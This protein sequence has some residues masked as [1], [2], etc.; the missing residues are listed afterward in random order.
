MIAGRP[1]PARTTPHPRLLQPAD[2]TGMLGVP[3]TTIP[4]PR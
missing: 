1:E 2:G 3:M 4:D